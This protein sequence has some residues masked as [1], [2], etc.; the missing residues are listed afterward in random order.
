[1]HGGHRTTFSQPS[2]SFRG[3]W[4]DEGVRVGLGG[5]VGGRIKPRS[6]D[7]EA[8]TFSTEL[9]CWPKTSLL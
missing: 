3:E 4:V 6:L 9:S 7:P 5:E 2:S 1:M 8:I